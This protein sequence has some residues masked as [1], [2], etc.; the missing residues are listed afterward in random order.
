MRT[1]DLPEN[2]NAVLCC[3]SPCLFLGA[4]EAEAPLMRLLEGPVL[5]GEIVFSMFCFCVWSL[6]HQWRKTF[7][8]QQVIVFKFL[9]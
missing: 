9:G 5:E 7:N 4:N 1:G 8:F 3:P 2:S 6:L